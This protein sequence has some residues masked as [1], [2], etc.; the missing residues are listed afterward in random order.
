MGEVQAVLT[1]S[2]FDARACVCRESAIELTSRSSHAVSRCVET[3]RALGK[4]CS[5]RCSSTACLPL[6]AP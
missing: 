6:D 3:E 5:F 1:E 2:G 4:S